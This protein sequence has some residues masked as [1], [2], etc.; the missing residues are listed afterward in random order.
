MALL[1]EC[2]VWSF[3]LSLCAFPLLLIHTQHSRNA[4]VFREVSDRLVFA[5][6]LVDVVCIRIAFEG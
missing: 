6:R 3:T 4:G 2:H 5:P 1:L